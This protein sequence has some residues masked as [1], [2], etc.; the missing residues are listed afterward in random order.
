[1][2]TSARYSVCGEWFVQ[3]ANGCTC[4]GGDAH[5]GHEPGC[6]YEPLIKLEDLKAALAPAGYAVIKLPTVAFKGPHDTDAKFFRQVADRLED[7]RSSYVG[8]GNV[9]AAVSALLRAAAAE[10]EK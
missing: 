3:E 6:G 10:A 7:G 5:Y 8:G 2:T 4:Y 1:M 9:R